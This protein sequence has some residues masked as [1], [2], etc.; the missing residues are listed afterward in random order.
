MQGCK[1]VDHD[2]MGLSWQGGTQEPVICLSRIAVQIF[3]WVLAL[4]CCAQ[5]AIIGLKTWHGVGCC[6][7]CVSWSIIEK[8]HLRVKGP[9]ARICN[10]CHLL[11][12]FD[13]W[14][15]VL[16]C[17]VDSK[18]RQKATWSGYVDDLPCGPPRVLLSFYQHNSIYFDPMTLT[19]IF[20]ISPNIFRIFRE[21]CCALHPK[22]STTHAF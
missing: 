8:G 17:C 5:W 19:Y 2:G 1:E 18:N 3:L 20:S 10:P 4:L 11:G 9:W 22:I 12:C 13:G 15:N 21:S 16:R 7:P 6:Y 14:T